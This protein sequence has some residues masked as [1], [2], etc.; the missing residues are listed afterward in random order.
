MQPKKPSNKSNLNL[1]D[2]HQSKAELRPDSGRLFELI[3]GTPEQRERED[4]IYSLANE[5]FRN[6]C[7]QNGRHDLLAWWDGVKCITC[8]KLKD[9]PDHYATGCDSCWAIE[10]EV[11]NGELYSSLCREAELRLFGGGK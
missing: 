6:Y 5:M 4:R 7:A 3:F 10:C 8:H 9:H 11:V 2:S 1:I